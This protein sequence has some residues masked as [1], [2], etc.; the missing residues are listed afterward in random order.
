[1]AP[2]L[3]S[4]FGKPTAI[5]IFASMGI[6]C[7][8]ALLK[9]FAIKVE[10]PAAVTEASP[11]QS[12]GATMKEAIGSG[13][14]WMLLLGSSLCYAVIFALV[15]QFILHLRSPLVGFS[16]AEAAWA[17]SALFFF[18]L[19]GKSFF[20]FLSDRFEKRAVNL[21]CCL[22]TLAGALLI[23]KVGRA[24]VWFFCLIFG[25]GY[26][27]VTVTTRLVLA[28]LFGLRSLGKL[29][30]VM[31]S[32]ET[33]L[34]GGAN[35]L[36]GFLFD[37]TGSYQSAFKVMAVCSIVSVLL[38]ALLLRRGL[39]GVKLKWRRLAARNNGSLS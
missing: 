29:L 28:E 35:L 3:T 19:A 13:S 30:A 17:Y 22:M 1:V 4:R 6:I 8:G 27:G 16:A 11:D 33:L 15:Q 21:V 18:S 36:T 2:F 32:A 25:L 12:S 9:Y 39:V 24:N 38:M 14:Y 34:G 10:A 7:L 31:M 23:L 37:A 20:G 26:G 5:L